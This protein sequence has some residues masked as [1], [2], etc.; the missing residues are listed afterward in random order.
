MSF[1]NTLIFTFSQTVFGKNYMYLKFK[2]V[3][4]TILWNNHKEI[5]LEISVKFT[6]DIHFHDMILLLLWDKPNWGRVMLF[7]LQI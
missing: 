7:F 3:P 1:T 2:N 4:L 6:I 5:C